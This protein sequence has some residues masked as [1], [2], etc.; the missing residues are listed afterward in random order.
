MYDVKYSFWAGSQTQYL[1][2]TGPDG[3]ILPSPN[4]LAVSDSFPVKGAV[5]TIPHGTY[6]IN[7]VDDDGI[8]VPVGAVLYGT[9]LNDSYGFPA[10]LQLAAINV[11]IIYYALHF[12]LHRAEEY[13]MIKMNLL[14]LFKLYTTEMSNF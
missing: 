9:D 6:S 2:I 3:S 4:W 7:A 8:S 11:R 12:T 13:C 1:E 5:V 10:G 14:L